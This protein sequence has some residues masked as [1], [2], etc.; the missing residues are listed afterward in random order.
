MGI[1]EYVGDG[2][3]KAIA[4]KAKSITTSSRVVEYTGKWLDYRK[5]SFENKGIP[6]SWE[7]VQRTTRK[8]DID[9]VEVIAI[10]KN[11]PFTVPHMVFV[12]NYRPPV[13][14]F[15]IELPAGLL[16]EGE[17][18]EAAALRELKEETG[19]T[20][21]FVKHSSSPPLCCDPWKSTETAVIA[22]VEVDAATDVNQSLK[23]DLDDAE[24]VEVLILPLPDLKNTLIRYKKEYG[25][26]IDVHIYAIAEGLSL[27][28]SLKL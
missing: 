4:E 5:V 7:Y 12:L 6:G 27:A 24:N 16:D 3:A 17:T 23:Q 1:T 10:L 20:G 13:A 9:G 26:E 19:L 28:E 15:C 25:F 8:G 22:H 11:G 18:I 2:R 14:S 21:T